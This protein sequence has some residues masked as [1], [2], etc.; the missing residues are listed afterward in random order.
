MDRVCTTSPVSAVVR[1]LDAIEAD[2][3]RLEAALVSGLELDSPWSGELLAATGVL[4]WS[5]EENRRGAALLERNRQLAEA[6]AGRMREA[7]H[8]R[9]LLGTRPSAPRYLDT[10]A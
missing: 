9:Q 5:A 6:V 7:Q 8:V 4:S 10:I 2:L 1:A 3:D